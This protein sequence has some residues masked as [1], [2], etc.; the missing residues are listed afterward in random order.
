MEDIFDKSNTQAE[1][2]WRLAGFIVFYVTAMAAQSTKTYYVLSDF[3]PTH[4]LFRVLI[5]GFRRVGC[6][7]LQLTV[8]YVTDGEFVTFAF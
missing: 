6:D 2:K 7:S 3:S 8:G 1:I 5:S 4:L